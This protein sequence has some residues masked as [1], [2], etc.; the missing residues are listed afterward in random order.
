MK[1]KP[2]Q[3]L[4]DQDLLFTLSAK[5]LWPPS[6]PGGFKISSVHGRFDPAPISPRRS[7]NAI[8]VVAYADLPSD[9]N[10]YTHDAIASR[11]P[12]TPVTRRR[13]GL[14]VE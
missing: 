11:T 13:C 7:I 5:Y 3:Y 14:A 6:E 2:C 4:H 8:A 9:G 1:E 12:G 10:T